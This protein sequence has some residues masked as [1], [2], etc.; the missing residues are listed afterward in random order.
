[1]S[2]R[3]FKGADIRRQNL[4]P[5]KHTLL[6][7]FLEIA[8]TIPEFNRLMKQIEEE[9]KIT[10]QFVK[11]Y[12][13]PEGGYWEEQTRKVAIANHLKPLDFID[14]LVFEL[15]NAS[16]PFWGTP[17]LDPSHFQT[18]NEYAYAC[19]HCE[20]TY[21]QVPF[22]GIFKAILRDKR[23]QSLLKMHGCRQSQI[24]NHLA[25]IRF[26]DFEGYLKEQMK[27]SKRE[28]HFDGYYLDY[29]ENRNLGKNF[30]QSRYNYLVH[31]AIKLPSYLSKDPAFSP[32]EDSAYWDEQDV[33]FYSHSGDWDDDFIDYSLEDLH[34]SYIVYYQE[35]I[36]EISVDDEVNSADWEDEISPSYQYFSHF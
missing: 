32:L 8:A 14:T 5:S 26:R 17:L 1:M 15:C 18:A 2:I 24:S 33:E 34:P 36:E 19:E 11:P 35:Y 12:Q 28:S 23:I 29:F 10:I 22:E 9:G 13:A 16:N 7:S 6:K 20:Y 4:S 25:S 27:G 30:N 31:H 3:Q 21:S